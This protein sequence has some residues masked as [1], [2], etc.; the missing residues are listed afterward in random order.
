VYREQQLAT[1]FTVFLSAL[2]FIVVFV[3][4]WYPVYSAIVV[5]S[6]ISTVIGF[7]L[8]KNRFGKMGISFTFYAF[9]IIPLVLPMTKTS[10]EETLGILI[11][12]V[13]SGITVTFSA[14]LL[15]RMF[16][17]SIAIRVFQ[18]AKRFFKVRRMRTSLSLLTI[19]V[20]V[21]SITFLS[22]ALQPLSLFFLS[23]IV[24]CVIMNT[25]LSDV[26][27]KKNEFLTLAIVG[28]NP[29]NFVGLVLAEALIMSFIG[30]G[31]G[32]SVGFW[33]KYLT[34][35]SLSESRLLFMIVVE[36]ILI[37]N[38][39]GFIASIIPASK[40]SMMMTPSL[41]KRWWRETSP[42]SGWPPKWTLAIP[43]KVTE[44][45]VEDFLF[46]YMHRLPFSKRFTENIESV[47]DFRL[48][49]PDLEQSNQK[50][51]WK[52]S[53]KYMYGDGTIM[54][55]TANDLIA[56][57]SIENDKIRITLTIKVTDYNDP[58]FAQR[59]DKYLEKIASEFRMF[60]FEWTKGT[61]YK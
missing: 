13:I 33:I 48:D 7:A 42:T 30:G 8:I 45:T 25:I 12:A 22:S 35:S 53:F 29:D 20:Y 57:K 6:V 56:S 26:Y 36:V 31:I 21:A 39:V 10:M 11:F 40:A 44:D 15:Q 50:K 47:Y 27:Q 52:L 1:M 5:W 14:I 54:L 4:Y 61:E 41:L 55:E 43:V 17:R 49:Y 60:A 51:T 58:Q 37:S 46:Y 9:F 59:M 3:C 34:N 16:H 2:C 32:Y 28:L 38:M 18:L 19:S 23:G 24:I